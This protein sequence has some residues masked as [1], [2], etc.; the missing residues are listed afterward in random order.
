MHRFTQ[1]ILQHSKTLLPLQRD[2]RGETPLEVCAAHGDSHSM[3][4]M[5]QFVKVL[6]VLY[7]AVECCSRVMRGIRTIRNSTSTTLII[8]FLFP[9][10]SVSCMAFQSL[11]LKHTGYHC[12]CNLA[13]AIGYLVTHSV[14]KL[15]VVK[16]AFS[17]PPA[18]SIH[19]VF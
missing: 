19:S 14:C 16:A 2:L 6:L 7:V 15:V 18:C 11:M 5:L 13:L 12:C 17:E 1:L 9:R 4:A 8:A 10:L 3:R